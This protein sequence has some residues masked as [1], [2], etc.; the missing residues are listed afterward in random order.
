MRENILVIEDN[1]LVQK[2]IKEVLTKE[3]FCIYSALDGKSGLAILDSTEIHGILL[4]L[5]L[6]DLEGDALLSFIR[7]KSYVPI[8]IISVKDSDI[9]KA[10]HLGL[11]ADDY[12]AKPFS[13]IELVARVKAML[14]RSN[15]S[16]HSNQTI[17]TIQGIQFNLG[18]YEAFRNNE[19]ILFTMKEAQILNLLISNPN[20]IYTKRQI[21]EKIWK[22]E[23]FQD[24]N[25]I[26]VHIR[27]IREKIENDPSNPSMI[28]TVWGIGY[29]FKSE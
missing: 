17:K 14:R 8:L 4:D 6:P 3:G 27:R 15:M 18:N 23:Y 28:H 22:D 1:N 19:K 29:V 7:K 21:Y 5:V 20:I 13:M 11:G 12:L 9:D 25:V 10:I 24:D 2:S 16:D 26:N